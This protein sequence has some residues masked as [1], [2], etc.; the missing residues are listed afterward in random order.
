MSLGVGRSCGDG[1]SCFDLGGDR[2]YCI[3]KSD[4]GDYSVS[5]YDNS[6]SNFSAYD[7]VDRGGDHYDVT[8]LN[9]QLQP[10]SQSLKSKVESTSI[11]ID[12]LLVKKLNGSTSKLIQSTQSFAHSI[13]PLTQTTQSLKEESVSFMKERQKLQDLLTN[14]GDKIKL[15]IEKKFEAMKLENHQQ[16]QIS[17]EKINEARFLL[18]EEPPESCNIN[19][20]MIDAVKACVKEFYDL[21]DKSYNEIEK[22]KLKEVIST[23]IQRVPKTPNITYTNFIGKLASKTALAYKAISCG[24]AAIDSINESERACLQTNYAQAYHFLQSLKNN[25]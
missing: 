25:K 14:K 7:K 17:Q 5:H 1:K 13:I 23:E 18:L 20:W 16:S 10:Q 6:Q 21:P 11:A 12:S 24:N 9:S 22:N 2:S 19:Q 4:H 15:A 3:S 8:T